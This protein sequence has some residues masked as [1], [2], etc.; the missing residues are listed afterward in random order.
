M[1]S[2]DQRDIA[3]F[4]VASDREHI[5]LKSMYLGK[6]SIIVRP[7]WVL[8]NNDTFVICQWHVND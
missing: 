7:E 4:D 6:R 2:R 8:E 3:A 1:R 5:R